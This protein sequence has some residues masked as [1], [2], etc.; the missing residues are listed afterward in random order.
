MTAADVLFAARIAAAWTKVNG[1]PDRP[2]TSPASRL[3]AAASA[4]SPCLA[5]HHPRWP[6][7]NAV[8]RQFKPH[9]FNCARNRFNQQHEQAGV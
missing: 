2:H 7:E 5:V 4:H 8:C 1:Q 9:A 3:T 6:D